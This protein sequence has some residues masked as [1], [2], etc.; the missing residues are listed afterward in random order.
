VVK[1]YG[2]RVAVDGVTLTV[3]SGGCFGVLGPNGAG[4][5]SMMRMITCVAPVTSG[6]LAVLG[7]DVTAHPRKVKSHLG[8][9]PQGMTLDMDLTVAEN[10]ETF[11]RYHSIPRRTIP[12]RVRELLEFASL[13]DRAGAR[14]DELSGGMQQRLLIARALVSDPSLVVLDEPTTGLDPAA[15]RDVWERLRTLKEAG[16]TLL[17]TTHY[18]EEA[19]Q[20]C[21]RVAV[22]NSGRVV[23]EGAP[24]DLVLRHV[25]S[26]VI[27]VEQAEPSDGLVES[28]RQAVD[29]R[30][31]EIATSAMIYSHDDRDTVLD[32]LRDA[33]IR[34]RPTLVREATLED[35]FMQL[36]KRALVD[37][38]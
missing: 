7:W 12:G 35:V 8:V 28:I 27:E 36:A 16:R 14:P 9:V 20:L 37:N 29:G 24:L 1:Q 2:D 23:A 6:H 13:T 18:M 22:V 30:V 5:T 17:L 25:G 21:D 10:L 3:P 4:K 32:R 38:R 34:L 31:E 19:T 33:R 26:T 15:R 11:A